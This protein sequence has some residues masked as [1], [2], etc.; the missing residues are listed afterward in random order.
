[1][2]ARTLLWTEHGVPDVAKDATDGNGADGCVGI[3]D[4]AVETYA[5]KGF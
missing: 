2:K 3:K 4:K 5:A 1:M